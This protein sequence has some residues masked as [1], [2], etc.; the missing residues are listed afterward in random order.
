MAELGRLQRLASS[1]KARFLDKVKDLAAARTQIE[2]LE[3]AIE[4]KQKYHASITMNR[5][6]AGGLQVPRESG[7]LN[8]VMFDEDRQ[9]VPISLK[10]LNKQ[11]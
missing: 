6:Q 2:S 1:T 4:N 10:L 9:G 7:R 3:R 5:A 8:Q 11:C